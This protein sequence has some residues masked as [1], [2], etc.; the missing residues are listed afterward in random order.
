MRTY[1]LMAILPPDADDKVVAG[2]TDRISEV[3]SAQQGQVTGVDRW[4]KRRL[5]YEIGKQSEGFYVVVHC[6]A[7][8]STMKELD[9]VLT[10]ADEVIRFKV[11]MRAA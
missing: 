3:L 11:V 2:V 8:P 5:A 9:R 10:L 6:Q 7:E 4:G 1:E